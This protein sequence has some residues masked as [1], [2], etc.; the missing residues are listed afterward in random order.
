M[1]DAAQSE[2]RVATNP[3]TRD[4]HAQSVVHHTHMTGTEYLA[5]GSIVR[6]TRHTVMHR[7]GRG[8]LAFSFMRATSYTWRVPR[9]YGF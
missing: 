4:K 1:Y 3:Q 6:H 9:P 7:S 8:V 2:I 5:W